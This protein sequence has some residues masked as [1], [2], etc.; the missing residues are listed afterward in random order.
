LQ[1]ALKR[2][3]FTPN[4]YATMAV[5][6]TLL[7]GYKVLSPI[8]VKTELSEAERQIILMTNNRLNGCA[9][10]M[11]A[12]T[13][14]SQMGGFPED[15]LAALRNDIP[16]AN[17]KLEAL[18]QL[19]IAINET[20]GW[21]SDAQIERFLQAGYT[22][23][24]ILEVVLGTALKNLSNYTNHI[25]KTYL[26]AAF[27]ANLCTAPA[28]QTAQQL[29]ATDRCFLTR[30]GQKQQNTSLLPLVFLAAPPFKGSRRV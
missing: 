20:R 21:P 29:C 26:D 13:T 7:E 16:I 24:T 19:A 10:S 2:Y 6:P 5:A 8:F 1:A 23:Q 28:P 25:A 30:N 4:L 17:G 3:G 22:R 12:H 27:I 18:R 11:A 14:L 9:Y 15:V